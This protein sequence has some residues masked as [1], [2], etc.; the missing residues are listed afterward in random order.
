M[1][2]RE[3]TEEDLPQVLLIE[4]ESFTP[5]WTYESFIYELLLESSFFRVAVIDDNV[6]GFYIIR[7]LI[8][9]AEII[10]LAVSKSFRRSGIADEL[11]QSIMDFA[12]NNMIK[13]IFL[14]VRKSNYPAIAL[15]RKYNFTPLGI[16]KDY[17]T[18]PIEDAITMALK[19]LMEIN[20][21]IS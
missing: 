10:N 1:I 8:D 5:P 15:Y 20:R 4:Q 3:A 11:M 17:Y 9:E 12:S 14:E 18:E 2:I 7:R 19:R 16:R 6:V 13:T 21:E